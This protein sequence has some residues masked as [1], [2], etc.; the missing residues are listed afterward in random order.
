MKYRLMPGESYWWSHENLPRAAQGD[1]DAL[2]KMSG[3]LRDGVVGWQT[4]LPER[5][6]EATVSIRLEEPSGDL[7]IGK[8]IN[9]RVKSEFKAMVR[10]TSSVSS[11]ILGIGGLIYSAILFVVELLGSA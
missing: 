11:H 1:E 7:L 9:V 3:L 6:G 2:G 10:S 5:S 4:L 8:Q